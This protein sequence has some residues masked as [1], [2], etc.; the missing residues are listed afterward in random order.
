MGRYGGVVVA[1][2]YESYDAWKAVAAV[3]AGIAI[4][5]MLAKPP[6]A[7]TTVVVS[8]STYY[9]HDNVYYTRVMSSGDGRRTR[10]S[11]R[12]RA[13]S[14]R[15][16][17]AGCTSVHVGGATYTQCGPTYYTKVS[18]GYQVVVLQCDRP[19]AGDDSADGGVRSV[20]LLLAWRACRWRS[21][22]PPA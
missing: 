21:P 22:G 4:G 19:G 8:G 12:P 1:D 17:P 20:A 7:A 14:S 9:Y 5:T 16:F 13:R 2:R 6:A 3:G 18:T 11:S 10:S 15:R